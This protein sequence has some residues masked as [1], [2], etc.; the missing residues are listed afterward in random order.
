VRNAGSPIPETSATFDIIKNCRVIQETNIMTVP[1]AK[2]IL[3]KLSFYDGETNYVADNSFRE[4]LKKF[5]KDKGL[6]PDG[7]LGYMTAE[8]LK[9][10][11]QQK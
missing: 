1:E 7:L 5:Q 4:A 8:K 3:K 10:A 11:D 6:I 9:D 2:A